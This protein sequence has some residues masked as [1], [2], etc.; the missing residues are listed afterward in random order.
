MLDISMWLSRRQVLCVE[1]T[2]T[3]CLSLYRSHAHIKAFLPFPF[4]RRKQ[5]KEDAFDDL[6]YG[7]RAGKENE[8]YLFSFVIHLHSVLQIKFL[9]FVLRQQS[10]ARWKL[11]MKRPCRVRI[12]VTLAL[13]MSV[14]YSVKPLG[15]RLNAWARDACVAHS[16]WLILIFATIVIFIQHPKSTQIAH[17]SCP[18]SKCTAPTQVPFADLLIS[19]GDGKMKMDILGKISKTF[20]VFFLYRFLCDALHCLKKTPCT[21]LFCYGKSV[22]VCNPYKAYNL[23]SWYQEGSDMRIF[24]AFSST[25]GLTR[26]FSCFSVEVHIAAAVGRERPVVTG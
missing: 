8:Q 19:R 17:H 18:H 21:V 24:S 6:A 4:L 7:V 26:L 9:K 16:C 2:S 22:C 23:V 3:R 25:L 14:C 5:D 10:P 11:V 20:P 12:P 15:S 1:W 13:F